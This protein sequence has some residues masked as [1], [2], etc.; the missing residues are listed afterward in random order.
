MNIGADAREIQDG[1]VTGIGRSLANFIKSFGE[2]ETVHRLV[3]FSER[4][5]PLKFSGNISQIILNSVPAFIWDQVKLPQ[6]LKS[7]KIDLF[8]SPYYKIPLL[9]SVPVVN[10]VL[11]LMYLV[12][13]PYRHELGLW[14]R[15]Y[16]ETLGKTYS[17]KSINIITDSEH[18]KQDVI[19]LWK[20]D[21]KKIEVIPLGLADR[22]KPVTDQE[23]LNKAKNKFKLPDRFIL[24]LGNFKPHKNVKSLVNAFDKIK[25]R[26]PDHKLVLAGPLDQHGIKLKN[27]TE[28][29]G[30]AERVVFTNT[31]RESDNPEALLSL[32]EVFVFPTLYE[33][34][35]LP[36]LE[37]MACGT[38]VVASNLT[39]VPEV[40]GDSGI[41]VNP[42]N[43]E[44][45]SKAITNLIENP[46]K[47]EILTS[48]GLE[49]A[50]LFRENDTSKKLYEHIISLLEII[51]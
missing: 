14:R 20:I 17:R 6:S 16:Y 42:L 44:E 31:I 23:L 36:P 10:Q 50:M 34:F 11:D 13:P 28:N 7:N 15:I 12:F 22:Y 38:P 45:I 5:V 48:K 37:A 43:V 21:P 46:E 33:G 3:L 2:N 1:V 8:Y 47:R 40:V 41:K 18:A 27:F 29:I 25:N 19:R 51:K 32:A 39:S 26:F 30:I 49:R 9:S 24:Y 35:G 4:N